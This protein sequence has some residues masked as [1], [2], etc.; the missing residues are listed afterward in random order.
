[1]T[2][3]APYVGVDKAS[4]RDRLLVAA[5]DLLDAAAGGEV[6][7]RSICERAEVQA[8]TLY[9]HFGTK[10]G[11]LD[12]VIT[13]GF[14]QFLA[15][16]PDESVAEDDPISA[17]RDGWDLHVQYGLE[18]P[19]FYTRIY[20]RPIPA[21]PCGVVSQVEAM[22]LN[23]LQ[24]AARERRLRV[25]PEHAARQILAASTGVVLTL[26]SQPAEDRDLAL[27][28]DVRGAILERITTSPSERRKTKGDEQATVASAAIALGAALA[29]PPPSLAEGELALLREW[30]RRLSLN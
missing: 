20:G 23:A 4:A 7:T 1:M 21:Q 22:I 19:N 5:A 30:L 27:S 15:E 24:P 8:P 14:K 29:E 3:S 6:S 25:A 9:H 16:R 26:I 10:Q 2:P 18:N 11:L 28:H 17:I 13:H 12:A